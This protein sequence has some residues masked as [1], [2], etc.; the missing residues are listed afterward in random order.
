M[1]CFQSHLML[2]KKIYKTEKKPV[3]VL[4][5]DAC[6]SKTGFELLKNTNW[7]PENAKI[8]KCEKFGNKRHRVLLSPKFKSIDGFHLHY[9]MSKHSGTGG[10]IITPNG[11]KYLVE[12]SINVDVPVDHFLFN[13]NNSRIF[14]IL[15]HYNFIQP[16]VNKLIN[17]LIYIYTE[18]IFSYLSLSDMALESLKEDI[19]KLSYYQNNFFNFYL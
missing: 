12:K 16:F 3:L 4:E 15:S 8:I 13:P 18:M 5:D 17:H 9:L 2:W 19:M 6:I 7:I 11:A 14:S 10:Y 1:A